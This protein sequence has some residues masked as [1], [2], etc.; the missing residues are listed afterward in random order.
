M[1]IKQ[2][3]FSAL[4]KIDRSKP[5]KGFRL[6]FESTLILFT[7]PDGKEIYLTKSVRDG[8]VEI[9]LITGK[10]ETDGQDYKDSYFLEQDAGGNVIV[11]DLSQMET[12]ALTEGA[13]REWLEECCGSKEKEPMITFLQS[14]GEDEMRSILNS[15]KIMFMISKRKGV[16]SK[17]LEK[18]DYSTVVTCFV[19]P[20]EQSF[21]ERLNKAMKH[22]EQREHQFFFSAPWEL[23][24]VQE[25]KDGVT[26]V[27]SMF[28][29]DPEK[30]IEWPENT[31]V[32]KFIS[33]LWGAY[34]FLFQ[35]AL[36]SYSSSPSLKKVE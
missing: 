25:E 4:I 30:S 9:A 16:L 29:C 3:Y 11:K 17:T 27:K 33:I 31:N 13:L 20:V 19:I 28:H 24:T 12:E 15:A 23:K 5:I 8:K 35:E 18:K 14:M 36:S 34:P 6:P 10:L 1:H 32:R 7:T 26:N 21:M 2:V 22:F